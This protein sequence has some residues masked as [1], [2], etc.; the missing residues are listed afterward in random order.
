MTVYVNKY[1]FLLNT[2][3]NI[4]YLKIGVQKSDEFSDFFWGFKSDNKY[5]KY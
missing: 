5:R 2:Y 4:E 3:I 1:K